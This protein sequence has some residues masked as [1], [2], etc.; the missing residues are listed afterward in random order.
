VIALCDCPAFS[1]TYATGFPVGEVVCWRAKDGLGTAA[2]GFVQELL[3]PA[4]L[5]LDSPGGVLLKL[6]IEAASPRI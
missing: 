2:L 4:D 6:S 3:L 5:I 1:C